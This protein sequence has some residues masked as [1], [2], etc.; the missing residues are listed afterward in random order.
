M[1]AARYVF[2]LEPVVNQ[3]FEVQG[4]PVFLSSWTV[5]LT[6]NLIALARV[7]RLGGQYTEVYCYFA[8]DTVEK[9]I[10][11]LAHRRGNSL[12]AS[13]PAELDTDVVFGRVKHESTAQGRVQRGDYV[14]R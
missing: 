3:S 14:A 13:H 6:L 12:Y 2:L 9:H 11:D 1:T 5:I 8:E 7:D 10:L 4:W